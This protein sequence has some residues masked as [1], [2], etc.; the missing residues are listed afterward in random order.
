MTRFISGYLPESAGLGARSIVGKGYEMIWRTGSCT[1]KL[2]RHRSG[3][4]DNIG[5]NLG[6][7]RSIE[8]VA[9][10]N[11][12]NSLKKNG[13]CQLFCYARCAELATQYVKTFDQY[14][15]IQCM[16]FS[17]NSSIETCVKAHIGRVWVARLLTKLPPFM[18]SLLDW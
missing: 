6:K 12:N 13:F 11:F 14:E 3:C 17:A 8:F 15:D 5:R 2:D 18:C 10:S 7:V 16:I 1:E 4:G 9:W